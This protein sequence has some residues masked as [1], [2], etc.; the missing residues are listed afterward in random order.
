MV[1]VLL[2]FV[3]VFVVIGIATVLQKQHI[4]NDEGARKFIHIGVAN[5]W[6]IAIYLMGNSWIFFIPPIAFIGINYA[7]YRFDLIKSMERNEK[8]KN[9]L[10][11][12]YYAISLFVV[13]LISY[14]VTKSFML[15]TIPIL[16]MGYGDGL[17]AVIGKQFGKKKLMNN[18]TVVGTVTM[19]LTSFI[20]IVLIA[21]FGLHVALGLAVVASVIELVS[22]RGFDNLTVPIGLALLL[23]IGV[24]II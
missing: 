8:S 16:V 4:L 24:S 23:A 13:A 18:K 2:S 10:G 3:F 7:S 6:L 1:E 19:F 14:V 11:T 20:V 21:N 5:W 22:P 15:G 17:S 12:V 9:D